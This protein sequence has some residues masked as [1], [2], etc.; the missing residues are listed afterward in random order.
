MT[1]EP[2]KLINEKDRVFFQNKINYCNIHKEATKDNRNKVKCIIW[3]GNCVP[4][5]PL[6]I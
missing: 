6:K 4:G 2:C 3:N 5:T 1:F